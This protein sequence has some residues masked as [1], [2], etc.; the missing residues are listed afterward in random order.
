MLYSTN[1][2][3]SHVIFSQ[4]IFEKITCEKVTCDSALRL[5][6]L[7]AYAFFVPLLGGRCRPLFCLSFFL[8]SETIHTVIFEGVG[9]AEKDVLPGEQARVSDTAGILIFNDGGC[10]P[11]QN[12]QEKALQ[13]LVTLQG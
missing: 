10:G 13:V 8:I 12:G 7:L 4:I 1:R 5:F 9:I 6:P 2:K 11:P 3:K